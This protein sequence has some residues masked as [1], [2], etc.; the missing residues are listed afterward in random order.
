MTLRSVLSD[1]LLA[2]NHGLLALNLGCCDRRI[3]GYLGVDRIPGAAVDV[4]ADLTERWPWNDGTVG[5]VLAHDI[6]EHLPDKIHTMNELHRVLVVG[7]QVEIVVPTTDGRAAWQ[8]PTHVSFWNRNSLCY[9]E[10]GNV[11][12]ERF[13]KSYGITAAFRV[14]REGQQ[15]TQ[16]GPKLYLDLVKV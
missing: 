15:V 14:A 4:V 3:P 8:D 11:Y 6:I 1:E 5:K 13:A 2:L 10:A 12:R 9:F 7:G 16:D